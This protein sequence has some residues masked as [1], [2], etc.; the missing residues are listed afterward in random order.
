MRPACVVIFSLFSCFLLGQTPKMKLFTSADGL[1]SSNVYSVIQDTKGYIWLCTDKGVARFDGYSFE[2]FTVQDGLPSNDIWGITEDHDGRLWLSTYDQLTYFQENKFHTLPLTEKIQLQGFINHHYRKRDTAHFFTAEPGPSLFQIEGSQEGHFSI[3]TVGHN[4]LDS[5][6]FGEHSLLYLGKDGKKAWYMVFLGPSTKKIILLKEEADCYEPCIVIDDEYINRNNQVINYEDKIIFHSRKKLYS[7]DFNAIQI[8]ITTTLFGEDCSIL[9]ISKL[10]E[11]KILV[12]TDRGNRIVNKNLELINDIDFIKNMTINTLFEDKEN[13]LWICTPSG[14]YFLPSKGRKSKS[15]LF[16]SERSNNEITTLNFNGAGQLLI[17]TISGQLYLLDSN[18][19]EINLTWNSIPSQEPIFEILPRDNGDLLIGHNVGISVVKKTELEK[20]V[21]TRDRLLYNLDNTIFNLQNDSHYVAVSVKDIATW[22]NQYYLIAFSHGINILEEEAFHTLPCYRGRGK[23]KRAHSIA[24][25]GE[26]NLWIGRKSGLYYLPNFRNE[27]AK[28]EKSD[29]FMPVNDIKIRKN[30]QIWIATDGFGL[31][32][33]N[34]KEFELIPETQNDI[35][36]SLYVDYNSDVWMA[37]N[38]GVKK[39]SIRQEFPLIYNIQKF[40]VAQGLAS[41][42]VNRIIADRERIYFGTKN[43]LTILE[44]NGN[45]E[46]IVYPELL[47]KNIRINDRDTSVKHTYQLNYFQ[48][49]IKLEYVCFSYK[50]LRDVRYYYQ[51]TGVDTVWRSTFSLEQS[52]PLLPPGEY[53]FRLQAEDIDGL[54]TEIQTI[55]FII[56]SPWWER[57]W[58]RGLF[59]LLFATLVYGAM[60]W[61]IKNIQQKTEERNSIEKKFAELELQ[62]LQAQMNPH[63]IFNALQAIQ[64]FIFDKD[65]LLANRYLVKFSRLMRLFLE[66]SKEKY[67]LLC[68]EIQLLSLYLE[69]EK[70]R[71]S[72]KFDYIITINPDIAID[73]LEIPSM[74]FQPF[75][76]NAINHGLVH[77]KSKGLLSI[78]I[79]QE[80]NDLV[81]LI[82]DDGIGR[83]K[84]RELKQKSYQSYKSRGMKLVQERQNVINFIENANIK[85]N[86]KDLYDEDDQAL[87]TAVQ[88]RIR[89]NFIDR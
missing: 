19:K 54:R 44:K 16:S 55:K 7:F 28:E 10:G 36:N 76:E 62:A 30:E 66:S 75:V 79:M 43:G 69:L 25:D 57:N 83:K 3:R 49:N 56:L 2:S 64:E 42:E 32:R 51:M 45:D 53:E 67:I 59:L 5:F 81:C 15:F 4:D 58:I 85:I 60:Q 37:T 40:S 21:I 41:N 24:I 20:G 34:G 73:L 13:N 47:I 23:W 6:Q 26:E 70:M 84:A 17:G 46:H 86:I 72:D 74:L 8:K 87:G 11:G 48:N 31:Y 65:E 68:D 80:K 22:K 39:L 35:I 29:F 38:K 27:E 61:R 88:I 14:L 50:S 52:Y 9:S 77:K 89:I 71:F 1:P 12:I 18:F 78:T 63:F 33:M 82:E